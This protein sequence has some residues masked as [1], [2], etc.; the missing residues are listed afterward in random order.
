MHNRVGL[1]TFPLAGVF[2]P[3]TVD[4]AETIVRNF[5][6][7]GGYYIDVAPMYG[8]GEIEQLVG[9]VLRDVPRDNYYL[10]TKTIKLID[11]NRRS[12]KSGKRK[13][14][15][16]QIDNSLSRLKVDF[17]DLL[18]VHSPDDNTPIEETLS[19]ME[20]LQRMGKVK[21]LAISNVNLDELIQY[22]ATKKIK[23]VQNRF[24]LINRSLSPELEKI[25]ARQQNLF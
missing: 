3:I 22:N 9:R 16:E 21:E 11:S 5:I 15:I 12:F 7:G 4:N 23:Y 20:E 13:D 25:S 1:G 19:A 2:S 14:V 10:A 18:M 24:S 6:D 17:V 8:N